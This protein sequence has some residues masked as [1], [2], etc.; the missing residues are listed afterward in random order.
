MCVCVFSSFTA[1]TYVKNTKQK[2]KDYITFDQKY[3]NAMLDIISELLKLNTYS[4]YIAHIQ[5]N[6][7]DSYFLKL[8]L[9]NRLTKLK[10]PVLATRS[11]ND[12]FWYDLFAMS[13]LFFNH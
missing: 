6:L 11:I 8:R 5:I 12:L 3:I 2:S 13:N 10:P 1:I 4:W 9:V 7:L